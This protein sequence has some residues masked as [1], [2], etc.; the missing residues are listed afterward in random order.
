MWRRFACFIISAT[1]VS[2]T[3]CTMG[4][5]STAQPVPEQSAIPTVPTSATR[6]SGVATPTLVPAPSPSATLTPGAT[7]SSTEAH[8]AWPARLPEGQMIRVDR[9][10]LTAD[11]LQLELGNPANAQDYIII[12]SAPDRGERFGPPCTETVLVRGISG[13]SCN[14][15]GGTT[16]QWVEQGW[17]YS[18]GGALMSTERALGIAETLEFVDRT[19]AQARLRQP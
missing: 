4:A 12:S 16:V 17:R 2:L 13:V 6:T 15:G 9:S 18:I 3:A 7:P 14:T 5:P 11:E 8:F 19:T 10:T 1:I